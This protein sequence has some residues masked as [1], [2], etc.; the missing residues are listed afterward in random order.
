MLPE[1][2]SNDLCSLR[3]NEDKYAFSAVFEMDENADVVNE[4]FGRTVIHSDRRFAY[5]EAQ[6]RLDT[7]EGDYVTELRV[8][9]SLASKLE[10]QVQQRRYRLQHGRSR[11]ELDEDGRPLRVKIKRMKEANKLIED[12]MLLANVR[13]AASLLRSTLRKTSQRN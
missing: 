5:E 1:I 7:G 6:T 4:W 2:L 3:P 8:F 10:K 11:F 9:F 13:V 12:F